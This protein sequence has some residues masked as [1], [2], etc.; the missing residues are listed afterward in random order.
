MSSIF[1]GAVDSGFYVLG[2][3]ATLQVNGKPDQEITV[4]PSQNDFNTMYGKTATM[5]SLNQFK[6]RKSEVSSIVLNSTLI[7]DNSSYTIRV[8]R[9]E[10]SRRLIW[11]V[12]TVPS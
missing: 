9:F 6:I 4:I 11:T 8:A 2:I 7:V 10:D 5:S 12:D 3:P 1:D